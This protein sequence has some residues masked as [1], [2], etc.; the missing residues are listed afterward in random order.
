MLQ[1]T[2]SGSLATDCVNR[3]L[4]TLGCVGGI[5]HFD[6][7]YFLSGFCP[8]GQGHSCESPGSSPFLLGLVD[9]TPSPFHMHSHVQPD[10]SPVLVDIRPHRPLP[11][12]VGLMLEHRHAAPPGGPYP[13]LPPFRAA[14]LS[15]RERRSYCD[16]CRPE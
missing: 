15:S 16:I 5:V 8:Y 13:L 6:V 4:S 2:S 12:V 9:H 10:T 14:Q 11:G 7:T 1:F 3:L